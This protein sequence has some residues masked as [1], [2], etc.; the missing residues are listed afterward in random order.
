HRPCGSGWDRTAG[1]SWD[2]AWFGCTQRGGAAWSG[3]AR[4]VKR[5]HKGGID[6]PAPAEA[7]CPRLL[8]Q[9]EYRCFPVRDHS[10]GFEI[11]QRPGLLYRQAPIRI[12]P[13]RHGTLPTLVEH[14]QPTR[15][16]L[17]T[18]FDF[19]DGRS[20]EPRLARAL[21]VSVLGRLQSDR[22]AVPRS[23]LPARPEDL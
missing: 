3:V 12:E 18:D 23:D 9:P 20:S 1:A 4:R 21:A 22:E 8:T 2:S 17:P 14:T 7:L 19:D 11:G 13:Q 16:P 15:V 10:H 6:P 5:R